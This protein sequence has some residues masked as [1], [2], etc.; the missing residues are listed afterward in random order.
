[1]RRFVI[2]ALVA[3]LLTGCKVSAS[4][5]ISMR[6]DGSGV[7]RVRVVA[8]KDAV[9][10]VEVGGGTLEQRVPLAD[11]PAAGWT[12]SKWTR[13]KN[14]SAS[15]IVS[16]PFNRP[17]ELAGIVHELSGADGPLRSFSATR[18]AGLMSTK[19]GLRG[20][21]DLSS[22]DTGVKSDRELVAKLTAENVNIEQLDQ[23]LASSLRDAFRLTVRV[24][25]PGGSKTVSVGSGRK[26]RIDLSTSSRHL[27]R[28]L[29]LGLG[30][31]LGIIAVALVIAGEFLGPRR[32]RGRPRTRR[33]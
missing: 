7:V 21:V 18:A 26:V 4:V 15:I 31:L 22:I 25:V 29:L 32:R 11:L 9:G 14:G 17:D 13:S 30:V 6:S 5:H 24:E 3:G 33:S 1:M 8:D 10:A 23:R 27:N 19:Y 16:K 12:V 28:V 20:S 2:V